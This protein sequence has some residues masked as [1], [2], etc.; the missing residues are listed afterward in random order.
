MGVQYAVYHSQK[1]KGS[2]GGLGNHIDRT[3]GKEHSFLNADPEK[4]KLNTEVILPGKINSL[5]LE[6]AIDFRIKE[7]Y[8]GKKAIRKDAVKYISHILTGSH[9]KMKELERNPNEFRKWMTKNLEFMK[10]EFGAENIVRFTLHRDERTPHVHCVTVPITED[11]RLSAKELIGNRKDMEARQDRYGELMKEFGLARGVVGSKAKHQDVKRF[12][13]NVNEKKSKLERLSEDLPKMTVKDRLN[14]EKFL[15]RVKDTLNA[16]F[17]NFI[18]EQNFKNT[19]AI[20]KAKEVI[21]AN[22]SLATQANE[23]SNEINRLISKS[24]RLV[25]MNKEKDKKINKIAVSKWQEGISECLNDINSFL[26]ANGNKKQFGYKDNQITL[27][28][29][30]EKRKDRGVDRGGGRSM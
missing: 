10:D 22:N 15:E 27:T 4:I 28:D 14:P 5:P 16:K 26:K 3:P 13:G 12:Y 24:N 7:G 11:G 21:R 25:G 1:G 9:E 23:M 8:K 30:V 20:D 6:K 19:K 29:V 18:N 2:G 17:D